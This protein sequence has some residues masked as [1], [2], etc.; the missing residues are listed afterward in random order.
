MW[1]KVFLKFPYE[2]ASKTLELK[3]NQ[4]GMFRE[5]SEKDKVLFGAL[6]VFTIV[7]CFVAVRFFEMQASGNMFVNWCKR[8]VAEAGGLVSK[9]VFSHKKEL[10]ATGPLLEKG[11]YVD[12]ETL[13]G[14]LKA[15]LGFLSPQIISVRNFLIS[16]FSANFEFEDFS[17]PKLLALR[18]RYKL[19]D[20]IRS[21]ITALDK[22]VILRNWLR[23]EINNGAPGP[24]DYNFNA[25]DILARA[26]NKE[27]FSCSEY[28]TAFVQ[29]ALS[30][31]YTARYAGL[32]KG[33][34]VAEIWNDELAKWVV[35]DAYNNIHYE[36]G[37]VPLG[38]LELHK[39][40]ERKDFS[41][42]KAVYGLK[43]D[44]FTE[45][46]KEELLSF[47]HEFYVR[48]RND[49]FLNRYPHWHIKGNSV[50]NALEWQDRYTSNNILVAH[51][52]FNE[53]EINFP[54]NVVSVMVDEPGFSS[55]EL[56]L[57][58]NTFTPNFSSFSINV[59]G[60]EQK[61]QV[62]PD[63]IWM[64]HEG[65]NKIKIHAV[66]TLGIKGPESSIEV[67]LSK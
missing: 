57:I 13:A 52:T 48:M 31:G 45:N 10:I 1:Y 18:Q 19:S 25:L 55:K 33:H 14:L 39:I 22:A 38:V 66:N 58:L 62:T 42:V 37:G 40:W 27:T 3:E 30:M 5:V 20:L 32:F 11:E 12:S 29:C 2:L 26:K 34:V 41:D 7:A 67:Y 17:E 35:M 21:G 4:Q 47:Y 44:E 16:R 59:D 8:A 56:R 63:F 50:M 24:V 9:A 53:E 36:R 65:L 6:V 23:E 15:R 54:V 60:V 43:R 28:S 64:L 49:W 61:K 46:T 51:E